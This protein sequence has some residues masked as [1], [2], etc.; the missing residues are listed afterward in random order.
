MLI[1]A[2]LA[3]VP[4]PASAKTG[5]GCPHW[6]GLSIN[7]HDHC[8][9]LPVTPKWV[10]TP[11]PNGS[12]GEALFLQMKL[13]KGIG[14]YAAEWRWAA[15]WTGAPWLF[16]SD[17]GGPYGYEQVWSTTALTPQNTGV[18]VHYKV[19]KGYGAWFVAAGGGPGPC[20]HKATIQH[21]IGIH[22]AH[23]A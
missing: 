12:C 19:P 10:N 7:S 14:E 22:F 20:T 17:S 21:G 1:G 13:Q 2:V 15:H 23:P 3:A 4:A 8:V 16:T 5:T 9:P 11:G 18:N 6:N